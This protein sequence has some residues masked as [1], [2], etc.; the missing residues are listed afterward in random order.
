MTITLQAHSGIITYKLNK[1][2][3]L[4]MKKLTQ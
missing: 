1:N 3:C 4:K 2:V